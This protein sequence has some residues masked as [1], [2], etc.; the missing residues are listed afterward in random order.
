MC[1]VLDLEKYSIMV[2]EAEPKCK[3]TYCAIFLVVS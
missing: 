1:V 2:E 3:Q